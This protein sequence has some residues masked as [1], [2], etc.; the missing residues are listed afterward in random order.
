MNEKPKNEASPVRRRRIRSRRGAAFLMLVVAVLIVIVGASQMLVQGEMASRRGESTRDRIRSL[1]TAIGVSSQS[2]QSETVLPLDADAD[3][4]IE[5][6]AEADQRDEGKQ[7]WTARLLRGD[8][9]VDSLTRV[10]PRA[11]SGDA[12]VSAESEPSEQDPSEQDPGKPEQT[13]TDIPS[14]TATGEPQ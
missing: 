9:V 14:P 8:Q 10:L 5:V 7:R 2:G 6:T 11:R 4:R 1:E 3:E 12:Q 13:E